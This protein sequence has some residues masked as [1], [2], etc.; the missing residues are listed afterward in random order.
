MAEELEVLWKKLSFTEEEDEGIEIDSSSTRTAKE[1]GKKCA[2]MKVMSHKSINLDALRKN[3]RML[4][5][6]NKGVQI[7]VMEDELF[8][9]E[10]SDGKDKKKVLDMCPWSYEKKLVLLQ[11]FDGELSP[12]EIELKGAPFWIQIFNLP[13][14]CRTKDIGWAIGSKLG[15]VLEV[16]V[17]ES[18]VQWAR[19]L[20]VRVR[21]D[22]TKRLVHGKKITVEGGEGRWVQFKYE[23]LPNFYYRCGLL[24]HALK[25]CRESRGNNTVGEK[26]ELQYEAWLRG[27]FLRRY[28]QNSTKGGMEKG[29][30]NSFG[31][32]GDETM[33][34]SG[35]VLARGSSKVADKDDVPNL[36][37]LEPCPLPLRETRVDAVKQKPK[38]LH[39]NRM[40]KGLVRKLGEK[41]AIL[42]ET[43]LDQPRAQSGVAE[44]M[45]WE[46]ATSPA[47]TPSSNFVLAPNLDFNKEE[48]SPIS[49]SAEPG[50]LVKNYDLGFGWTT[51]HIGPNVGDSAKEIS[52]SSSSGPNRKVNLSPR[53]G[54][55]RNKVKPVTR[56]NKGKSVSKIG[57]KR[58]VRVAFEEEGECGGGKRQAVEDASIQTAAADVQPRRH[59]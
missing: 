49:S 10:F 39:K 18:G 51:K 2:L 56:N 50:S 37:V 9:V 53:G 25:D 1:I 7:S 44:K 11:E 12:K 8:L 28:S 22:V 30:G 13:L 54:R 43:A 20:R 4:W 38:T 17:S 14:K 15:E 24:S 23:R 48:D 42:D 31:E 34:R 45:L 55:I 32:S 36:E 6:P 16:N 19:C 58:D 40:V 35:P 47:D 27:E 21:I 46:T 41:E 59:Q 29:A 33:L 3:M 5:K 57:M 52:A 26:E